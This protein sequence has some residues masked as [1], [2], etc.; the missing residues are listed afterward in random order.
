MD[1][2][3]QLIAAQD[4][5]DAMMVEARRTQQLLENERAAIRRSKR[6]QK[7]WW[8]AVFL[9]GVALG[10]AVAEMLIDPVTIFVPTDGIQA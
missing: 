8:L 10:F 6:I 3:E 9:L 1:E 5:L 4:R 2:R 7:V